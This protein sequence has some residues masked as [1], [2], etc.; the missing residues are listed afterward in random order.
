MATTSSQW[1]EM[2]EGLIV[3][4]KE[5]SE[6]VYKTFGNLWKKIKKNDKLADCVRSSG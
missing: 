6:S 4:N 3:G 5:F 2:F 1:S